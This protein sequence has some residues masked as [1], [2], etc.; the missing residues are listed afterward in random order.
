VLA[1]QDAGNHLRA[2]IGGEPGGMN[3]MQYQC[4]ITYQGT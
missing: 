1:Q 4:A 2:A 3:L